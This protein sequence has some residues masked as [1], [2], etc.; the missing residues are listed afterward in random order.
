MSK[1]NHDKP[2]EVEKKPGEPPRESKPATPV[3]PQPSILSLSILICI[4]IASNQNAMGLHVIRI[5][6]RRKNIF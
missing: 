4:L 1:L 2:R 5:V 3:K 6:E